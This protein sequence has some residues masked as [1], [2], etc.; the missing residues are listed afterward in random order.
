ML[1]AV[2]AAA[3]IATVLPLRPG[4]GGT[5]DLGNLLLMNPAARQRPSFY[6]PWSVEKSLVVVLKP[7]MKVSRLLWAPR[8]EY[9]VVLNGDGLLLSVD[10]QIPG[11]AA[12]DPALRNSA[13][14][15]DFNAVRG[16]ST[17]AHDP[18]H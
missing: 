17:G 7:G 12:D 6:G 16:C 2:G 18:P 1:L 11:G 14:A 13:S 4:D 10:D 5:V 15:P 8:G 9:E 3:G